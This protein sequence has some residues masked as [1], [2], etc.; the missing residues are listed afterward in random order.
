[1]NKQ[2]AGSHV[3]GW[4]NAKPDADFWHLVASNG[5]TYCIC[6]SCAREKAFPEKVKQDG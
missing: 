4:C 3:C 1:M 5:V 2:H 6:A